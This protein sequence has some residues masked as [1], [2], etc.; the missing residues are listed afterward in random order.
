ML[1]G[2]NIVGFNRV[3]NGNTVPT[4]QATASLPAPFQ[5]ATAK[6]VE[7]AVKLATQAAASYS[8]TLPEER[9]RFLEAIAE[10]IEDLGDVLLERASVESNLPL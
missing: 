8:K 5:A 2:I 3:S 1:D 7:Q 9:A 6:D 4:S 10:E